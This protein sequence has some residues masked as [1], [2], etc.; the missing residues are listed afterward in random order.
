MRMTKRE[1]TKILRSVTMACWWPNGSYPGSRQTPDW[2]NIIAEARML[3][4]YPAETV[5]LDHLRAA[6]DTVTPS[7]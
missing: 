4:R 7:P 1:A 5:Y 2:P 6:I 3:L